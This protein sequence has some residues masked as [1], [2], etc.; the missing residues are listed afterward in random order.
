MRWR[1][2]L[3]L[4]FSIRVRDQP[5]PLLRKYYSYLI[6]NGKGLKRTIAKREASLGLLIE[7]LSGMS[8]TCN[9]A[10]IWYQNTGKKDI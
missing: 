8:T 3:T 6:S 7:K 5:P 4:A 9:L 2:L 1:E 10:L